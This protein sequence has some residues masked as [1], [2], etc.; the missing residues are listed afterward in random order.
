M[1]NIMK[2]LIV[3]N[4][5][6]RRDIAILLEISYSAVN[7]RL[8]GFSKWQPGEIEKV[9]EFISNSVSK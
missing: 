2:S 8:N 6:D 9:E 1:E 7:Q 3:S 5:I 4:K